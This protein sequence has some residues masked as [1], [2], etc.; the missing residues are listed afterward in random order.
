[1][2]K[3]LIIKNLNLKSNTDIKMYTFLKIE[4]FFGFITENMQINS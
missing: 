1:M 2:E 4:L 3:H